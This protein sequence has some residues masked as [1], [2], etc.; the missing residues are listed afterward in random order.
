[1]RGQA[2]RVVDSYIT[3]T[4]HIITANWRE[5]KLLQACAMPEHHTAE[6]IAEDL[7][8]CVTEWNIIEEMVPLVSHDSA[9]N[10]TLAVNMLQ[11]DGVPT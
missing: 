9:S 10:V 1:M 3:I 11:W 5:S 4:A 6:N 7:R 2:Y 8:K